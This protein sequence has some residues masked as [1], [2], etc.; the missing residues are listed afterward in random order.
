MALRLSQLE[1]TYRRNPKSILF[2]HLADLYLH[3]DQVSRALSLCKAGCELLPDYPTG[4]TILGK[5]YQARG[6][7]EEA[8][9]AQQRALDLDPEN[10]GGLVRLAEIFHDLGRPAQALENLH[11]AASLDDLSDET[12]EL[13]DRLTYALRVESTGAGA[14]D[15]LDNETRLD[16]LALEMDSEEEEG[17]APRNSEPKPAAE[18]TPPAADSST[19]GN[20]LAPGTEAEDSAEAA[21]DTAGGLTDPVE[22]ADG[23]AAGLGDSAGEADPASGDGQIAD[24]AETAATE[25]RRAEDEELHLLFQEIES[26]EEGGKPAPQPILAAAEPAAGD[27]HPFATATLAQIYSDQGLVQRAADT[28]RQVL[29]RDP[30]NKEIKRR[31]AELE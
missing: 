4:F 5:C 2:A 15:L 10:P 3:K 27:D 11:K 22:E 23:H 25:S 19:P 14:D 24:T 17:E 31:L 6:D 26:R 8:R 12:K 20:G 7:L 28:Y 9:A 21:D 16:A 29:A 1:K 18:S 13:M 30:G